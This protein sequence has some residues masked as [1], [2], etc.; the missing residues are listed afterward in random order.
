MIQSADEFVRL[1]TSE[2]HEDYLRASREEA[3]IGVW[4]DVMEKYPYSY[5]LNNP[6]TFVD[7]AA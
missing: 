7:P 6:I 3:A 5:V 4:L 2:R 1:R